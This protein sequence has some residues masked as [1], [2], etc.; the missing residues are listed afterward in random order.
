MLDRNTR[1]NLQNEAIKEFLSR[2][3]HQLK[4]SEVLVFIP[5]HNE[6]I[7]IAKVI[8]KVKQICNFDILVVDDGSTDSTNSIVKELGVEILKHPRCLGSMVLLSGL[9]VGRELKYKYIIKIDGDDQHD[10]RDIPRLHSHAIKTNADVVIGSRHLD[11]YTGQL[12]SVQGFGMWFCSKMVT[13]ISRRKTTDVTS[14]LKIWN[15]KAAETTIQAFNHGLF[16]EDSTVLIEECLFAAKNGLKIE[17][18]NVVMFPR[19][20][21]ESKS[22]SRGKMAMFPLNLARSIFRVLVID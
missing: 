17:E 18:I 9:M 21:G 6:E 12:W 20:H 14:G 4:G 15:S 22:Y 5:V 8:Q 16:G 19:L 11:K 13:I 3:N 10:A 2:N 1:F 7:T